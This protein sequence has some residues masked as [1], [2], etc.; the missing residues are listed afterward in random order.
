ME[1]IINETEL[2]CIICGSEQVRTLLASKP[3]CPT[4]KTL[5]H[6]EPVDEETRKAAQE[7]GLTLHTFEEVEEEVTPVFLLSK[8]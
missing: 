2:T 6:V 5:I 1:H 8:N 4:L 3:L 7:L